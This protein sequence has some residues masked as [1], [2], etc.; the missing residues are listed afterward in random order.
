MEKKS[1]QEGAQP[2][3]EYKLGTFLMEIQEKKW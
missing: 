3:F 2:D 1:T